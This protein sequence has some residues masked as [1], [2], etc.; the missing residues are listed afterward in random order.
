M[1][2]WQSYELYRLKQKLQESHETSN[3]H[4]E[5]HGI[6]SIELHKVANVGIFVQLQ[7][8]GNKFV[9]VTN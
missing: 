2:N 1:H 4:R 5:N 7:Q 6:I 9:I 3:V 8:N